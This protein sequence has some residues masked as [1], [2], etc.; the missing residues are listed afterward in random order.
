[1]PAFNSAGAHARR[2]NASLIDPE[3]GVGIGSVELGVGS[4]KRQFPSPLPTPDSPLPTPCSAFRFH[5]LS[6]APISVP[7][8]VP[9]LMRSLPGA[10][11]R[12]LPRLM[13]PSALRVTLGV[14]LTKSAALTTSPLALTLTPFFHQQLVLE[15]SVPVVWSLFVPWKERLLVK[16]WVPV[17]NLMFS[18]PLLNEVQLVTVMLPGLL[19]KVMPCFLLLKAIERLMM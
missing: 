4:G 16:T 10:S 6:I 1:M 19:L 12:K 3:R 17:S 2:R 9:A 15:T 7:L 18:S 11:L 14:R 13:V 8:G 5:W